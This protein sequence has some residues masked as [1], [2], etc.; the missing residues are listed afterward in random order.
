ME[1]FQRFDN[2][3]LERAG[4]NRQ[5]V[6]NLDDLPDDVAATVRAHST[7]G[8][9]RQLILIGH[10]GRRLWQVVRESGIA[11]SD[12]ID[13]FS[14]STVRR[15]FAECQ[16][17]NTFELIYPGDAPIGLQRLGQLAGWHHASP[18]MVGIDREWGSWFA[19]RALAVADTHFAPS[20]VQESAHPCAGCAHK[21]CVGACPAGALDGGSLD[22]ARCVAYR[23][24][25]GSLCK[26]NCVARVACPVGAEHRYE[27]AHIEHIYSRSM[28]A[29]E[30]YY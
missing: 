20:A 8:G 22:F 27:D 7:L 3:L 6:F 19:Y 9:A 14:V 10:A 13:D 21:A 26:A 23:K 11:S 15:W 17:Q 28:Q 16:P 24:Q 30:R 5:A 12:P 4:L 2:V 18:F 29:I 1:P 25:A